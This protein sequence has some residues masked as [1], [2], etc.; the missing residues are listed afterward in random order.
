MLCFYFFRDGLLINLIMAGACKAVSPQKDTGVD[1]I[2]PHLYLSNRFKASSKH[3]I[4]A[5]SFKA[6]S[7]HTIQAVSFLRI[8]SST[9]NL[10]CEFP[11]KHPQ[12][13]LFKL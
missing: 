1:E 10:S 4:Q 6:S 12:N 13:T 9:Q 2:L 11:L 7:K 5:V 8:A 3:T